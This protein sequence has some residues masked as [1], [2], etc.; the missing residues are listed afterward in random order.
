[1]GQEAS[2]ITWGGLLGLL[3]AFALLGQAFY[4]V[5]R[6][7]RRIDESTESIRAITADL[8]ELTVSVNAHAINAAK[9]SAEMTNCL[10]VFGEKLR[11]DFR[12]EIHECR[13]GWEQRGGHD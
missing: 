5:G 12:A 13:A 7:A 9:A 3:T 10:H 6:N 1:M 4:F 8:R 2:V 11:A